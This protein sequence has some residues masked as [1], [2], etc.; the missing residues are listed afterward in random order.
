MNPHTPAS[1][2]V[3]GWDPGW[4]HPGPHFAQQGLPLEGR[5]C[6]LEAELSQASLV[7]GASVA[8]HLQELPFTPVHVP[9]VAGVQARR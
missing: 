3:I 6:H 7:L 9:I 5:I 4:P 1:L 8:E 2:V